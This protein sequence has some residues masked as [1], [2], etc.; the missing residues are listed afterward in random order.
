[1]IAN[2]GMQFT[3][4]KRIYAFMNIKGGSLLFKMGIIIGKLKRNTPQKIPK[5]YGCT[6]RCVET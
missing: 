1:M 2:C 6:C 3:T 4:D 5:S